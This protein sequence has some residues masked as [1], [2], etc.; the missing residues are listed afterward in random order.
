MKILVKCEWC[1]KKVL[2]FPS[3]LKQQKHIFC[4]NNRKCSREWM[5]ENYKNDNNHSYIDG[6]SLKKYYCID[7]GEE[8][9]IKAKR[10]T[11]CRAL[12]AVG[13]NN[14]SWKRIELKCNFCKKIYYRPTWYIKK[15]KSEY[16]YCSR[17]CK[18]VGQAKYF[19]GKK[20]NLYIHGKY[21]P[22]YPPEFNEPL[23]AFIRKRDG[24]KCMN[25]EAPQK[26]FKKLLDVHHID[27]NKKHN[28][29]VNLITLCCRCHSLANFSRKYWQNY[30]EDMQID[31]KVHLLD[32]KLEMG[33]KIE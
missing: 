31:R 17:K 9:S 14:P 2:I 1:N 19:I 6:R 18:Q 4:K 10:C 24:G 11:G 3:R 5:S 15:K 28:D 27:Y 22:K 8:I 26:E 16:H 32:M 20:S 29:T 30:Y 13:K 21:N 25:C 7:C 33:E 12:F 23:K